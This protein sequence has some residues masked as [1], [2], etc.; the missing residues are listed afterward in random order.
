MRVVFVLLA[1][2]CVAWP[3]A[4]TEAALAAGGGSVGGVAGKKLS[5]GLTSVFEKTAAV[6]EKTAKTD[7]KEAKSTTAS[8]QIGPATVKDHSL[9]PPPP[10]LHKTAAKP[11]VRQVARVM[12]P[13]EAPAPPPPPPV[14]TR[15]NLRAVENGA[16]RD[17]VLK[18]GAPASRITMFDGGHLVEIYR[19]ST[20]EQSFGTVR[21]SDG[22]VSSVEV[23][24]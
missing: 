23:R 12:E 11:A 19:Y 4:L 5:D 18:L 21:L 6:A 20:P 24:P 2:S 15:E 9:V 8:V 22:S 17:E 10:P 7:T 14:A 13:V 16:S 1:M 3:Q